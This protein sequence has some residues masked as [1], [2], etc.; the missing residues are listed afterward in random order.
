MAESLAFE[1]ALETAISLSGK[2]ENKGPQTSFKSND[3]VI[4][5]L[6]QLVT[7]RTSSDWPTAPFES[8]RS[9][10]RVSFFFH[11]GKN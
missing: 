5:R 8:P 7:Q 11:H 10:V 2:Q 6:I 1:S 3:F 4:T 9:P